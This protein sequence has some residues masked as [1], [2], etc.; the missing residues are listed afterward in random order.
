[1]VQVRAIMFLSLQ[2]LWATFLILCAI[3]LVVAYFSVN[4]YSSGLNTCDNW[5]HDFGS[6][7]NHSILISQ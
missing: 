2:L 7:F 4:F 6:F 5:V 1:M 3:Y